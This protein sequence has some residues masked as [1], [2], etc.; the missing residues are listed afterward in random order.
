MLAVLAGATAALGMGSGSPL[1]ERPSAPPSAGPVVL[2]SAAADLAAE[3]SRPRRGGA[4]YYRRTARQ[5]VPAAAASGFVP[6]YRE[7]E[8]VF[9]VNWLL[10]ASIHRQETAF[11]HSKS[12]YHGLNDFGCCAGPMQFNVTNGPPSTWKL[13]R[14]SYRAAE[15]PERYPHRTRKHPSI[16]DDFDAIMA[17]GSLLSDSGA[18]PLLDVGAWEAAYAYYGHDLY[19]V[20]YANEVVA[21]AQGWERDGFC[22]DCEVDPALV[23]ELEQAYGAA[24]RIELAAEAG[25]HKKHKKRKKRGSKL[26]LIERDRKARERARARDRARRRER[27]PSSPTAERDRP[28]RPSPPRPRR[29]TDP[30]EPK[31]PAAPSAPSPAGEPP[32]P[33]KECAPLL[34]LLGCKKS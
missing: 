24:A 21:R 8:R 20:T 9:G 11:S 13:Y 15:R 31:P 23:A 16:Y 10:I 27:R 1:P 33:P 14:N 22:P 26:D 6:L 3:Q 17:A 25:P 34:K 18:G 12:T 4:A 7:A 2:A 30:G 32:A 19:G 5:R 29:R 28:A